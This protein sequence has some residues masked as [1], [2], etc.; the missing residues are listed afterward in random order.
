MRDLYKREIDYMRISIT[1]RCNLRCG[2]CMPCGVEWIPMEQILTY[3][4]IAAVCKEAA[5]LGICKIKITGGEPL[6]RKGCPALVRMIK[7]VPGIDQ[8]TLTT[9]GVVLREFAEELKEAGVDG[10][11]VSL[12]TLDK[13]KFEKI[14]GF[15]RL[16]DVLDGIEKA[17]AAG[18]RVK[19]NTVLMP[20]I[21]E[22]AWKDM[23]LLAEKKPL[24]IRFIEMMPIGS[25]NGIA[26]VSNRDV[27][28][29]LENIYGELEIDN[30][31]HG[32]GP[33][34]YHRIPGFTGGVGFISAIHGKF[35]A[36]CNRIRMTAKGEIKPCLCY[37][38]SISIRDVLRQQGE[39]SADEDITEKIRKILE[40]AVLR[41]PKAHCFEERWEITEMKKMAQIGG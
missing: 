14:T 33:A 34:V 15:D 21:N 31:V 2:Y 24:D 19:I 5:K 35:C 39:Q 25:G 11:N 10:I 23:V 26:S 20:G 7:S 9:N 12:D 38:E 22:T 29:E 40:E 17:L 41:K 6:V 18:I 36:G 3:E 32:N 8:V 4:E 13:I 37:G 16:Q 28:R 30:E 1:D 27:L